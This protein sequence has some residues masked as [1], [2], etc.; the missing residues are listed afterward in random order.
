MRMQVPSLA[1]LRGLRIWHCHELWYRMQTQLGSGIAVAV[2]SSCSSNSTPHL[3]TSI[4]HRCSPKRQTDRQKESGRERARRREEG[5]KEAPVTSL[6]V[7]KG[8]I[9]DQ[10]QRVSKELG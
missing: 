5:R 4:C 1:S 10:R 8:L 7:G 2:A 3:G 6:V 9:P